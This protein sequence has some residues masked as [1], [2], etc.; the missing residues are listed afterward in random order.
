MV[1]VLQYLAVVVV[2][3]WMFWRIFNKAGRN[4]WWAYLM[5][6]PILG[7]FIPPVTVGLGLL[8]G[9]PVVMIWV[10]AFVPWPS[11]DNPRPLP[12]TPGYDPPEPE[13]FTARFR[14]ATR[15]SEAARRRSRGIAR[16]LV[17]RRDDE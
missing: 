1:G 4:P 6:L 14:R 3:M 9:L 13:R 5:L 2:A 16:R 11:I 7:L 8:I 10:L 12:D 17:R 15:P